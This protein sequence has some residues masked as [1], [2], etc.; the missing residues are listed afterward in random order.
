[1]GVIKHGVNNLRP[2]LQEIS[3]ERILSAYISTCH[4]RHSPRDML[5]NGVTR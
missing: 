4:P 1:M 3:K 2:V 5:A